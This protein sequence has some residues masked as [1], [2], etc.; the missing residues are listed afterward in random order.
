MAVVIRILLGVRMSKNIQILLAQFGGK[1]LLSVADLA[2]LFG[3]RE[4]NV[5]DYIA[6]GVFPISTFKV[7][8]LRKA[9]LTDVADY[10]DSLKAVEQPKR[11]GRRTAQEKID[12][13]AR[14]GSEAVHG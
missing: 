11:V 7:G 1:H 5:R 13:A 3:W 14:R 9:K 2:V 10:L 4:Q 6:D 8:H 12:A